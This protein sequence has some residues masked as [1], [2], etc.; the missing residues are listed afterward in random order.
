MFPL[1]QPEL[2]ITQAQPVNRAQHGRRQPARQPRRRHEQERESV[3]AQVAR[4]LAEL[5]PKVTGGKLEMKLIRILLNE[6]IPERFQVSPQKVGR[7]LSA[8]GFKK[9]KNR[10]YVY[11]DQGLVDALQSQYGVE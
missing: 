4:C 1:H 3:E 7:V 11:W 5:R 9:T 10:Q 8:F 6:G 2:V